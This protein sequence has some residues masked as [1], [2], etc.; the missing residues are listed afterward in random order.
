MVEDPVEVAQLERRPGSR[1]EPILYAP[2]DAEHLREGWAVAL[3][4]EGPRAA[5]LATAID[6]AA[7]DLAPGMAILRMRT[8]ADLNRAGLIQAEMTM[9]LY[10]FLGILCGGLGAVGLYG[11]IAQIVARRTPELGVRMALGAT[12]RDVLR[13]VLGRGLTL[14]AAG[15]AFGVPCAFAAARIFGSAVLDMPPV[16]VSILAWIASLVLATA[17]A[18]SYVPARR[19]SRVDPMTALRYE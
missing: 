2:L 3:L 9:V 13:L 6:K 8:L 19:A 1:G 11:A 18:A 14:A 4:V 16:D 15:V 17:L 12:R 5:L 7:R 10:T